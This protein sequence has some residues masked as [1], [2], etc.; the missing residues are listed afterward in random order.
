MGRSQKKV[1][2]IPQKVSEEN[3]VTLEIVMDPE[4]GLQWRAGC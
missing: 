1:K 3:T 2:N 4:E